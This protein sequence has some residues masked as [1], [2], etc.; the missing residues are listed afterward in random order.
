MI[1]TVIVVLLLVAGILATVKLIRGS[2]EHPSNLLEVLESLE[3]V[4]VASFRHLACDSDDRHLKATLS[5]KEYRRLRRLR[6]RVLQSYY[7]SAFRNSALLLSY[8][9]LLASMEDPVFAH[10]GRDMSSMSLQLRLA[11]LR[12]AIGVWACYLIPLDIP[13]WRQITDRY[14]DLG[15]CLGR[16]CESNFPDLESAVIEHFEA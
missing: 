8:G 7:S 12:G 10:F 2:V 3:P 9:E 13:Y 15:S 5:K 14:E 1:F 6:L 11:L 16:F 4:N